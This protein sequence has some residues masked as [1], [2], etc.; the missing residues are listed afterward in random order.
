M[1]RYLFLT[2]VGVMMVLGANAQEEWRLDSII[3]EDDAQVRL[4]KTWYEYN[5]KQQVESEFETDYEDGEEVTYRTVYTYD[6]NGQIKFIQMAQNGKIIQELEVTATDPAT[7]LPTV[8]IIKAIDNFSEVLSLNSKLELI[9][10]NGQL[11]ET[12][13]YR[14]AGQNKGQDVFNLLTYTLHTYNDKNQMVEEKLIL[15]RDGK[16]IDYRTT[17]YEYDD[18]G[19][20]TKEVVENYM[21]DLS[22]T[23]YTNTYDENGNLKKVRTTAAGA[24]ATN[25]LYFWS[26]FPSSGINGVKV[27][28]V[29]SDWYDLNG[30]RL[31]GKPTTKGVFIQNGKKVM[32]K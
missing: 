32:V 25:E 24:S 8:Y 21:G 14:Y 23:N 28:K 1:K 18:H 22:T 19:N 7:G 12:K 5:S 10:S 26:K 11:V 31:N 27:K 9:Y 13:D 17:T 6:K 15:C 2:L 16:E 3:V 29:L 20:V 4:S 30:K